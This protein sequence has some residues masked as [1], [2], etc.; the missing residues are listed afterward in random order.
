MNP[1]TQAVISAC[2]RLGANFGWSADRCNR[3]ARAW[4]DDLCQYTEAELRAAVDQCVRSMQFMPK[5][6]DILTLITGAR[7]RENVVSDG[8]RDCDF[9]GWRSMAHHHEDENGAYKVTECV[10]RCTCGMGL[11]YPGPTWEECMGA[12]PRQ[13]G[14]LAAYCTRAGHTKLDLEEVLNPE[15]AQA[16]REARATS[17]AT[18]SKWLALSDLPD[19]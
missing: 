16:I 11:R 8:C 4:E 13:E 7:K 6:V 17:G 5:L 18:A 19:E 3:I 14:H 12:W 2:H 15:Q 9:T 10:A 1:S